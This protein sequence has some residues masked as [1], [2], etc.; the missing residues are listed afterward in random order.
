[1]STVASRRST[2]SAPTPTSRNWLSEV[3][4]EVKNRPSAMVLYGVP[5]IGKTSFAC[6]MPGAVLMHDAQEHGVHE[7]KKTGAV[8]A[9]FPVLPAVENWLDVL[10]MLEALRTGEHNFT[11]IVLDTLGGF[12]RL[13][14]EEVCRRDYQSDWGKSGFVNYQQGY[15]TSLSDLRHF[16]NALDRLR[17]ERNMRVVLIGHAK[18][19]PFKNPEG[20]DYDRYNA[21]CHHKTWSLFNKWADLVLFANYEVSFAAKE[22]TKVKAKAKG[23]QT[24]LLYTKRT[25]AYDAKNGHNLPEEIE[26]GSNAAEAWNN[27]TKAIAAGRKAGV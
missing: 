13:C 8:T 23:G 16:I 26:M 12:E 5:G 4:R 22:E 1:M 24:P 19:S 7:L 17:D 25:A 21:D 6:Q 11:G 10:S 9:D 14:H 15:D 2:G 3:S 20:P 27:F 18:V